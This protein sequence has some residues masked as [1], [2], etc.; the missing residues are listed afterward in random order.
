MQIDFFFSFLLSGSPMSKNVVMRTFFTRKFSFH[1]FSG[2]FSKRNVLL[3][4]LC[5]FIWQNRLSG[6]SISSCLTEFR[7]LSVR[8]CLRMKIYCRQSSYLTENSILETISRVVG[9]SFVRRFRADQ[10]LRRWMLNGLTESWI[11]W[12]QRNTDEPVKAAERSGKVPDELDKIANVAGK[13]V[14]NEKVQKLNLVV[15]WEMFEKCCDKVRKIWKKRVRK[16]KNPYIGKLE[17]RIGKSGTKQ[18]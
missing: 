10:F 1:P 12:Y 11:I 15:T 16:M 18:I 3:L 7:L 9:S 13:I 5:L 2:L 8:L 4:T 14:H 6:P 17:D